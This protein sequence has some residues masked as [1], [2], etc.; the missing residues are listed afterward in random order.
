M[1]FNIHPKVIIITSFSACVAITGLGFGAHFEKTA[2]K[3]E[4]ENQKASKKLRAGMNELRD[5]SA[6]TSQPDAQFQ[7][8]DDKDF[9]SQLKSLYSIA[10]DVGLQI[11][12]AQFKE[13]FIE[14]TNNKHRIVEVRLNDEYPK[15]KAYI[16]KV[17]EKLPNS[18]MQEMSMERKDLNVAT[19]SAA[20]R[21]D[22]V[23]EELALT[24]KQKS[25]Q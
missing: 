25:G 21:F 9:A 8:P 10:N 15:I 14:E 4:T 7:L 23:Y 17:L 22:L 3:L 11:S 13:E 18:S 6:S 1:K 16:S 24:E 20:L 19:V 12:T 2:T 5:S